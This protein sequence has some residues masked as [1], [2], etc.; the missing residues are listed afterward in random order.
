M[1]FREIKNL[2]K[3]KKITLT[4]LGEK[5]GYSASFLSQIER[6]AN[7]PSLEAL[8]KIADALDVTVASL[9]ANEAPQVIQDD[10]TTEKG[11]KVI[12]NTSN[13]KYNPWQT[14]STYYDTLFNLPVHTNN[15]VISKIY[16]DAQSSSSGKKIAHN[17]CEIN[18][19]IKGEAT[20][21]L[22]D[23]VLVLNEGD[24][25]FLEAFTQ[26]NIMNTTE[27]ELMLFTLQF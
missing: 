13:T 24:A 25:I 5:T 1:E 26:H 14:N 7:R 19:V 3:E 9:L 12:R 8:R 15:M 17:L 20:V 2:R 4:E 22:K 16:I 27:N 11:Y 21:E 10:E 18:Y 23:E 6:G